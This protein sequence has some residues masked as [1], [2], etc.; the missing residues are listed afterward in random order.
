MLESEA[1]RASH[2]RTESKPALH[3]ND[4]G[5]HTRAVHA[6]LGPD[7]VQIWLEAAQLVVVRTV[8]VASHATSTSVMHSRLLAVHSTGAQVPSAGTHVSSMA[9]PVTLPQLRPSAAQV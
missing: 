3:A 8:P 5:T 9:H 7:P 1:P 2:S 4:P 6:A